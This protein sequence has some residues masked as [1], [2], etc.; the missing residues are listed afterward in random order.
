MSVAHMKVQRSLFSEL[1]PKRGMHLVIVPAT[2]IPNWLVEFGKIRELH[3]PYVFILL[4]FK[5]AG[6]I[7]N[8]VR[9]A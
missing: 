3:R 8:A 9:F 7:R 2:I 4:C 6:L 5:L 1:I